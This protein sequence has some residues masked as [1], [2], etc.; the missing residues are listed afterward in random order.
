MRNIPTP[1]PPAAMPAI[2]SLF[3]YLV[4]WES[5]FMAALAFVGFKFGKLTL[6]ATIYGDI[7]FGAITIAFIALVTVSTMFTLI[8]MLEDYR[9]DGTSEYGRDYYRR[10]WFL[11]AAPT[12]GLIVGFIPVFLTQ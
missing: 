1:M 11:W 10:R 12:L 5:A 9:H 3:L 6:R 2:N 7:Q 4:R 8:N